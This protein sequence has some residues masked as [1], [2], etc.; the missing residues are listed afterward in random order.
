MLVELYKNSDPPSSLSVISV[1]KKQSRRQFPRTFATSTTTTKMPIRKKLTTTTTMPRGTLH[2]LKPRRPPPTKTFTSARLTTFGLVFL[3][4][5]NCVLGAAIPRVPISIAK[6][7]ISGRGE[8]SCFKDHNCLEKRELQYGPLELQ[9]DVNQ[10]YISDQ[11]DRSCF[12]YH[13]CLEKRKA[14]YGPLELH[15]SR[16]EITVPKL[17][18]S[19]PIKSAEPFWVR[20]LPGISPEQRALSRIERHPIVRLSFIPT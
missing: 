14:Q 7:Y 5:T 15:P 12:R 17:R 9:T 4:L 18:Q 13:N 1:P 11:G 6:D 19:I 16:E 20:V 2:K 10:R 8:K 3:V